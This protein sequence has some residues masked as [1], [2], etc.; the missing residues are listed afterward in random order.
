MTETEQDLQALD[1][2]PLT[3]D[4]QARLNMALGDYFGTG[5]CA[6]ITDW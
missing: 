6:D 3:E 1:Q 5:C 4:E 2:E